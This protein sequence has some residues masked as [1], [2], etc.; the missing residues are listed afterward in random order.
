MV[1]KNWTETWKRVP[2]LSMTG[3]HVVR[4]RLARAMGYDAD[5]ED[6]VVMIYRF[7]NAPKSSHDTLEDDDDYQGIVSI[8]Q[9]CRVSLAP[10][11]VEIHDANVCFIYICYN[12][13]S[14]IFTERKFGA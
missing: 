9:A 6:Q 10:L 2:L 1:P 12:R 13:G 8:M 11:T 14:Y 7:S 5:E 4:S 3:W